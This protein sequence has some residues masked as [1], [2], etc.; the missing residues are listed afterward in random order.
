MI[1]YRT[2]IKKER[3]RSMYETKKR[4]RKQKETDF[5]LPFFLVPPASSEKIKLVIYNRFFSC[6]TEKK[7][8]FFY[9]SF[10]YTKLFEF[11]STL[12]LI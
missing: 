1:E 10:Q 6:F 4:M 2:G 12:S 5:R 11:M 7:F 9:F 8:H 3:R